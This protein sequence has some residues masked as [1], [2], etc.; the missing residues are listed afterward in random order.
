MAA[1][2]AAVVGVIANLTVWF[3]LHVRFARAEAQDAGPSRLL[4]PEWTSFDWRTALLAV[5][6]TGLVFRFRWSVI[7]VLGVA[8]LG[9]L[10]LGQV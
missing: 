8:A 1:L 6:A 7:G 3:A 10:M 9:G 2:T 4:V 5:L